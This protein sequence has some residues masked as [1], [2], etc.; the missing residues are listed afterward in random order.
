MVKH[1]QKIRPRT[2]NFLGVLDH[3]EGLAL[4]GLNKLIN[5]Y[6]RLNHQGEEK[7]INSL[8]LTSH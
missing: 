4:K 8:K 6:I 2:A 5:F 3:F 7:L 1:T